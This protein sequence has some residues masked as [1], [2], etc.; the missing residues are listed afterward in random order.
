MTFRRHS[1]LKASGHALLG[2]IPA[3]WTTSRVRYLTNIQ[4]GRLPTTTYTEPQS[5]SD[6]PYLSMEYLRGSDDVVCSTYVSDD[7]S[8]VKANFDDILVL[9]DG[10]NAGEFL[11]AKK[12]VV[13]STLAIIKEQTIDR[14]FLFFSLKSVEKQ[15]KDQTIGMGI[16]HVS[17]ETLRDLTLC[18]PPLEEQSAIVYFLQQET[19][20]IDALVAQQEKLIE[21][22]KE[23]RYVV[24]SQ[25]TTK[26]IQPNVKTKES[27]VEW[28]GNVP[29]H[30][31]LLP[32]KRFFQLVVDVA[33][34][35]NDFELLSLYTDIG[36]RPRKELEARGNRASTTDGYFKVAKGDIVVNKLLAWMGAIGVSEYDGVTSPAYD[37]LRAKR[38]LSPHY[39]DYLFR[40]GILNTEFR[41]Y[42]RG[43]MDMRLRLYFEELGQFQM[44][45]PPY[46][47]Q[48]KIVKLLNEQLA[49]FDQ[50][51]DEAVKAIGLLQE[52]RS[53][54]ISAAVT[55]RI[56]VRNTS[57][58]ME[59]A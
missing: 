14:D 35:D 8:Y 53:A 12:G 38:T 46:E 31:E 39:Y 10:S 20:K 22:L 4:K 50:L 29:E 11:R 36:V 28:L 23:K 1:K 15:L 24:I 5:D 17:S 34:N 40:C 21:L 52:R 33:P 41:R 19:A 18:V 6:I 51:S 27:G 3:A 25:A 7:D 57:A 2:D 56:D 32:L 42:S 58:N 43:I 47:E 59:A 37:I 54:L 48:L 44:P 49:H 16:P 45:F 55:G 9:W 13:S 30:W 26:G